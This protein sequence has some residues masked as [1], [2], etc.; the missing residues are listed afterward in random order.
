MKCK[1]IFVPTDTVD[2]TYVCRNPGNYRLLNGCLY[3]ITGENEEILC[4]NQVDK[5]ISVYAANASYW[6]NSKFT[7]VDKLVLEF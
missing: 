7:I 3:F 1:K 5:R 4:I 2:W 6:H